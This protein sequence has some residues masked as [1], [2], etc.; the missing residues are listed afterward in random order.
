MVETVTKIV[1]VGEKII[2]ITAREACIT[3]DVLSS[4]KSREI[5]S[6]AT[7]LTDIKAVAVHG[8][9]ADISCVGVHGVKNIYT[10]DT[11]EYIASN[12]EVMLKR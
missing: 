4:E 1:K 5:I 10:D 11:V 3:I 7:F 6:S 9:V 12:S 2:K 8:N